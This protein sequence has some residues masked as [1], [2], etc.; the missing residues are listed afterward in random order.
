MGMGVGL[1]LALGVARH[2]LELAAAASLRSLSHAHEECNEHHCEGE[3]TDHL[4]C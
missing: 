3:N 1:P 4:A 2:D